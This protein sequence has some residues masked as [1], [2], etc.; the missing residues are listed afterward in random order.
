MTLGLLRFGLVLPWGQVRLPLDGTSTLAP[1]RTMG[2]FILQPVPAAYIYRQKTPR[3]IHVD[4][5]T[6]PDNAY[7]LQGDGGNVSNLP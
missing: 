6:T 1:N 5:S 3:R 4:D 2:L 7:E